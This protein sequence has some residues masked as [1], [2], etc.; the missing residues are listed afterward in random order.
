M[1]FHEDTIDAVVA[2]SYCADAKWQRSAGWVPRKD[3]F[4]HQGR[5]L[6]NL[7]RRLSDSDAANTG[8]T[9]CALMYNCNIARFLGNME[10]AKQ[11]MAMIRHLLRTSVSLD[12]L[13]FQGKLRSLLLQ[14]EYWLTLSGDEEPLV[15]REDCP[16]STYPDLPLRGPM[17]GVVSALPRGFGP[18]AESG[19]LSCQV[20]QVLARMQEMLVAMTSGRIQMFLSTPNQDPY[21]DFCSAVPCLYASKG[22]EAGLERLL[23][24][25]LF[26]LTSRL[27][28]PRKQVPWSLP[29]TGGRTILTQQTF[30]CQVES[31]IEKRC[32][33]WIWLIA[34]DSWAVESGDIPE[35]ARWLMQRLRE[36]YPETSAWS[37]VSN[38]VSDFFWTQDLETSC[39]GYWRSCQ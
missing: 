15:S 39:E 32:L 5:S 3:V 8:I 9:I 4:I 6:A 21:P 35:T 27:L 19:R 38:V 12:S 34:I 23:C 16:E 24:C 7:R 18:L 25:A 33:I 13:G 31:D 30:N 1:I 26:L 22:G 11:H 2:M 37:Y 14:W 10:A 36:R 17:A 28:S 29:V 20:L